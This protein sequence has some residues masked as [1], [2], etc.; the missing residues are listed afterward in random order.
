[1]NPQT[2]SPAQAPS[3]TYMRV[4][5]RF[6][7]VGARDEVA[8]LLDRLYPADAV[9]V[10]QGL[11][12]NER[13]E[14]IDV[15]IGHTRAG[16]ILAELRP[17]L[18]QEILEQVGN[19]RIAALVG[20][21]EPDEAADLLGLL[22]DERVD[23]V[24]KILDETTAANLDRLMTYGRDTAG[25]LMT[26]RFVALN[27][28]VRIGDAIARI[29]SEPEAEMVF[30]L[31]VVDGHGRLEGVV[32]LRQLV[33]APADE[34]LRTIMN[35]KAIRVSADSSRSTVAEMIARY[36]LL[37]LPVV[38]SAN[39]LLGIV[40]V[41][42]AIDAM[43]D[44]ATRE[45]YRMAG[46]NTE[47][48]VGSAPLSSVRRRLP[49]MLLNLGTAVLAS[50]VVWLFEASIEQVVAL[51]VFL[52]IVAGVG[53]NAASQTLTVVIRGIALG[54][55]DPRHARAT[56]LR[57]TLVGATIGA[58]T[59]GVMAGI[60]ILWKG[61]PIL[62][63]VIGLAMILNLIIAGMMGAAIPLIL[64]ALRL[65]PALGSGVVVTTFTDCFGFLSFL[66]LATLLLHHLV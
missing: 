59:G 38:D 66:G 32:S 29:R 26:T 20:R 46:L 41:D 19:E 57:E 7:R 27:S 63:L 28:S 36:N 56:V 34:S 50:W 65:D 18:A 54:E 58:I 33:L 5:R 43:T 16:A 11:P 53:G 14:F 31:Y 9:Q 10:L 8:R 55:I 1:M 35:P 47:D 30:Y 13:Q 48:R 37:A 40:T 2:P 4:I 17:D 52:P 44:E 22:P 3:P 61:K 25:G 15:L 21:Q 42:D 6:V 12:P 60:A 49:W 24:L 23:A 39:T 45:M 64:Q 51:A 62:G